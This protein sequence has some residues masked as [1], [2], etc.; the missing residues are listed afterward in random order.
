M[1]KTQGNLKGESVVAA[2][3]PSRMV[4]HYCTSGFFRSEARQASVSCLSCVV[5]KSR[6]HND[7]RMVNHT[8]TIMCTD[9]AECSCQIRR[10]NNSP[11]CVTFNMAAAPYSVNTG[12]KK[13]TQF[14][15]LNSLKKIGLRLKT[16][17]LPWTARDP[18]TGPC[19]PH[20]RKSGNKTIFYL[21]FSQ[22]EYFIKDLMLNFDS[23]EMIYI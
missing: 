13:E 20:P 3:L 16:S 22:C 14:P 7:Y 10:Y 18:R 19:N 5:F 15:L 4:V 17:V 9:C 8:V 2:I 23:S 6:T 21:I 12:V 1:L 11:P